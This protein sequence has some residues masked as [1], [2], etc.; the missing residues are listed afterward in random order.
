MR[1]GWTNRMIGVFERMATEIPPPHVVPEAEED[2]PVQ[3]VTFL[4][5]LMRDF[6][7]PGYIE[8]MVREGFMTRHGTVYSNPDLEHY[9]ERLARQLTYVDPPPVY[10]G[11]EDPAIPQ[12]EA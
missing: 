12:G 10:T 3:L 5:L 6:I 4:Y 7:P 9:A 1:H 11:G 2:P 8:A